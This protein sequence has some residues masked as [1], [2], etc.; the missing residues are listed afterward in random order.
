MNEQSKLPIATTLSDPATALAVVR[1]RIDA[2]DIEIQQRMTERA[3]CALQVRQI[4][5]QLALTQH[6]YRPEREAKVLQMVVERNHGPMSDA[7]IVRIFKEMMSACLAEQQ[8]LTIGY[9]S[10]HDWVCEPAAYTQF[11]HSV[12]TKP[13]LTIAEL[14]QAISHGDVDFGV[15][16][17]AIDDQ[18]LLQVTLPEFLQARLHVC[19]YVIGQSRYFLLSKTGQLRDIQQVCGC[20]RVLEQTRVWRQAH[21]SDLDTFVVAT[22]R[23][24]AHQAALHDSMAT[25]TTVDVAP[26]YGLRHVVS[27]PIDQP[28]SSTVPCWVIGQQGPP[29]SGQD[30]TW[31]L[32]EL[33]A[34]R[35]AWATVFAVFGQHEVHLE[36][37]TSY[38]ASDG[39]LHWLWLALEGHQEDEPIRNALQQLRPQIKALHLL[40]SFPRLCCSPR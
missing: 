9:W 25:I 10:A 31:L 36:Q 20:A 33:A 8:P 22:Q 35:A 12:Q 15:V 28:A 27:A 14:Y 2:L 34:D 32:L 17:R 6:Y 37:I 23:Q 40:G 29:P 38:T 26:A 30:Q 1:Q 4:K 16:P 5:E 21:L 7:M 24:G 11:G 19:G 3:R 39:A 18:E 13:M